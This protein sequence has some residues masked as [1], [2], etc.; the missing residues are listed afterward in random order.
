LGVIAANL[1]FSVLGILGVRVAR[2][3][4]AES[5]ESDSRVHPQRAIPTML[6]GAGEGGVAVAKQLRSRPNL[7][8]TAVGFIDDDPQKTGMVVHGIKVLGTT[9][10]LAELC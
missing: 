8:L 1:A 7:G 4:L 6:V 3:M 10:Q 5:S 2:R 9:S